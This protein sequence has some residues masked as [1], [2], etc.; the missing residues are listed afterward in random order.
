MTTVEAPYPIGKAPVA[1]DHGIERQPSAS[2]EAQDHPEDEKIEYNDERK[3]EGV[4]RVEAITTVW[5]KKLLVVMFLLY[6]FRS[7]IF[8]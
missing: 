2:E 5:S 8:D 6:D 1:T 3:Q 7:P 4:K